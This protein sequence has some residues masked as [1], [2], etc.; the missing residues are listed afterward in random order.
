MVE[1]RALRRNLAE[2]AI[3]AVFSGGGF[4]IQLAV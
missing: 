4:S 1:K 3:N 2:R